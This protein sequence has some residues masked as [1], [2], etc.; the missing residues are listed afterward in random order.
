MQAH[1]VFHHHQLSM[2]DMVT[3]PYSLTE[4]I[5]VVLKDRLM[6]V[7]FIIIIQAHTAATFMM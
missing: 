5:A 1:L 6:S 7:A 3:V 2:L 4:L